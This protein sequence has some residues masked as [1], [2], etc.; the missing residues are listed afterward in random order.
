LHDRLLG[1]VGQLDSGEDANFLLQYHLGYYE[2]AR[3][4]QHG[5]SWNTLRPGLDKLKSAAFPKL[6]SRYRHLGLRTMLSKIESTFENC[7]S[8][9]AARQL[10]LVDLAIRRFKLR[11]D[12]TLPKSLRQLTPEF[13]NPASGH[14][15]F[16]TGDLKYRANPDGT[17]LLYSVGIDGVDNGGDDSLIGEQPFWNS[18]D[19]VWPAAVDSSGF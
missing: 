17:Y 1:V 5:E 19:M 10:L 3:A 18:R 8:T 9:E 2:A 4:L 16:G 6:H 7:A 11:H 14:D 15:I 12:G 13:L